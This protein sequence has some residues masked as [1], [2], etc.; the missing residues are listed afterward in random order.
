MPT[1]IRITAGNVTAD[2]ELNDSPTAAAIRDAL[3][4]KAR[5]NTWG[6][7]IYFNIPVQAEADP[8]ARAEV[9]VGDLAYWP[10]GQAFC[11]FYGRT[12]A[13]R[14]D[15]PVAASPVNVVGRVIGPADVFRPVRDG[16]AVIIEKV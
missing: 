2:A 13:S 4:I 5:G 11:V 3:P 16:A 10:P 1:R 12:P 9:A 14:G 8:A 15:T 6:L 7:E